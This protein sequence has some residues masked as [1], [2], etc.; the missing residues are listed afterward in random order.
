MVARA[1]HERAGKEASKEGVV[2]AL[3]RSYADDVSLVRALA[4]GHPAAAA[5]AWDRFAPLVE[6]LLF[7]T[8]GPSADVDDL[9]QD[10]FF[11]LY[12]RAAEI[13]DPSALSGFVVGVTMRAARSEL[14]RRRLRRWL[15]LTAFGEVPDE[16]VVPAD[17]ASRTAVSRLYAIL[18]RLDPDARLA[19]V[20]RHAQGLELVE[21]A[22]ALGCSLATA[23]RRLAKATERVLFHAER[24]PVLAE[25]V[26]GP[27]GPEEAP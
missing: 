20:L 27:T 18:D 26:T 19:F 5:E 12:R 8:L 17:H 13:R 25:W 14:R 16:P 6:S 15:S 3:R 2:R 24:D 21:V 4:E 23:K 22:E 1:S 11:V 10:V 9:L 7:R